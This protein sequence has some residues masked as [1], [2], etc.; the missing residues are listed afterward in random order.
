VWHYE[1]GDG[2]NFLE[3]LNAVARFSK[4]AYQECAPIDSMDTPFTETD[5]DSLD[6][7]MIIM[8]MAVIFDI[9]EGEEIKNFIPVTPQGM[10]DFIQKHKNRDCE[11][12]DW[13]LETIK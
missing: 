6:G 5:I 9:P 7:L 10:F 8:Y 12:V 1:L 13:A 2:M 11:S 3:L 4:P